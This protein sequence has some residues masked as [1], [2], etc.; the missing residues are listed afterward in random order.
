M[1]RMLKRTATH[2]MLYE[3]NVVLAIIFDWDSTGWANKIKTQLM[4]TQ[5]ETTDAGVYTSMPAS[6]F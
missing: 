1:C 5:Q 2:Y 4:S 6:N 3:L